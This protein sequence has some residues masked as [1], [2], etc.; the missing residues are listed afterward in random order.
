MYMPGVALGIGPL[1][2]FSHFDQ[3]RSTFSNRNQ[4][5]GATAFYCGANHLG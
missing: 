5:V 1:V 3:R 4:F 2:T